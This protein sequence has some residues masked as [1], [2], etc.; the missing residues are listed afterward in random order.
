MF[1]K[2]WSLHSRFVVQFNVLTGVCI[3]CVTLFS[4]LSEGVFSLGMFGTRSWT[5]PYIKTTFKPNENAK[6]VVSTLQWGCRVETTLWGS[7]GPRTWYQMHSEN[8]F[9]HCKWA[10][11][12]NDRIIYTQH[13]GQVGSILQ[14][15][16]DTG[17][18]TLTWQ[19]GQ[20][21]NVGR[22]H[23]YVGSDLSLSPYVHSG[24]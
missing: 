2:V 9:V 23:F 18:S 6:Y 19:W 22:A 17:G 15:A 20:E 1:S 10:R 7:L 16:F 4:T 8:M 3:C 21:I 12:T 5:G 24:I 13:P 14:S 11:L